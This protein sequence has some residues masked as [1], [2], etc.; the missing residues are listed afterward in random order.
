MMNDP[1]KNEKVSTVFGI[2]SMYYS[3]SKPELATNDELVPYHVLIRK[4]RRTPRRCFWREPGSLVWLPAEI[5]Y[6][7]KEGSAVIEYWTKLPATRKTK[8]VEYSNIL[9]Y[10]R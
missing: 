1:I 8:I 7:G 6:D 3:N 10:E 2:A 5:I 9:D 4:Q